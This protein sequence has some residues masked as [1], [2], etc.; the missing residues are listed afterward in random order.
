MPGTL[1]FD[2]PDYKRSVFFVNRT[3]SC[4][5][6]LFPPY[7]VAAASRSECGEVIRQ[8]AQHYA[9]I[10]ENMVRRYPF[11]WYHFEQFIEPGGGQ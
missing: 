5:C 10:L 6:T 3:G 2:Q 1:R 4:H 7:A 8:A 11:E 9:D